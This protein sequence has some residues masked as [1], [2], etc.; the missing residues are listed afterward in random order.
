MRL[1]SGLLLVLG[2]F[3]CA[4]TEEQRNAPAPQGTEVAAAQIEDELSTVRQGRVYFT[5]H[6]VGRD[7]MAGMK[8]VDGSAGGQGIRFVELE[9]AG[10]T[11]PAFVHASGGKNK[12]P[13]SKIDFFV[14][15]LRGER[16]PKPQLALMKF[17]YVD[18]DP[19]T[20]VPE[21]FGYYRQAISALKQEHPGTV[22]AHITT[23]LTSL[24]TDLKSRMFRLV[25]REVWGDEANV[26]RFEWNELLAKNFGGDP[27]FDLAR[28]ES[29]RANG[30][31]E[32]F[33]LRGRTYYGLD[34]S[35]TNDGGH[36]NALGQKTLG[37]E[38]IRFLASALRASPKAP[39]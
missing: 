29:T 20:N 11:G 2:G 34:P 12:D 14:S 5:H 30:T 38:M 4:G 33:Q 15:T 19:N 28:A 31:R 24:D 16:S 18:F 26:K 6:S 17:C 1:A 10:A 37:M 22:F 8:Q 32:A 25:G 23:P 36:L 13:R 35:Y 21:L 9:Q 7:L 27:I 39:S 3:A